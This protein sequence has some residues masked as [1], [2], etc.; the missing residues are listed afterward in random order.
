[1]TV[2]NLIRDIGDFVAPLQVDQPVYQTALPSL[3]LLHDTHPSK[4]EAIVYDPVICLVL[5]GAKETYIGNRRVSFG[6]GDSLIVSHTLPVMAAVT[7][8][9]PEKPYVAMVLSIDLAIARALYD[10]VGGALDE[11]HAPQSLRASASD[12]E[13]TDAMARLFRASRDPLEARALAPLIIREIHFRLLRAEHG[14]MLR[15]LLWRD[16]TASRIEKAISL[17]RRSYAQNLPVAE[18]AQIAGMSVSGF[19]EHFRTVTERTPLQFL[20]DL[21][22]TAARRMLVDEAAS[23]SHAAFEVGYE[24]PTQFSREYSRKFGIPPSKDQKSARAA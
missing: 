5:Q 24:S 4:L 20:K 12:A 2:P 10:E 7:Q 23:V 15:K 14:S 13:L 18:L 3:T 11:A 1:M 8:A 9:S 17:M 6:A 21:R 16:S 22:L 19:H